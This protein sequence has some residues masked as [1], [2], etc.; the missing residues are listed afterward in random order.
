MSLPPTLNS[1][2]EFTKIQ[3]RSGFVGLKNT[4]VL[5]FVL[6]AVFVHAFA[7]SASV[8]AFGVHEA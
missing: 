6:D 3:D 1:A 2:P 7:E 8:A 5:N 4:S